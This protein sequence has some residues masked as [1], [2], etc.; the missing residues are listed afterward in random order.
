MLISSCFLKK[1]HDC[2]EQLLEDYKDYNYFVIIPKSFCKSCP[3]TYHA[4]VKEAHKSGKIGLI[5]NCDVQ[6]IPA[7]NHHLRDLDARHIIIDTLSHYAVCDSLPMSIYP[8]IAYVKNNQIFVEYYNKDNAK[9]YE[10]LKKKIL[11]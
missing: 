10:K 6:Y 9:A 8:A 11:D 1:N 5:I 2:L 3:S 4:D 7:I